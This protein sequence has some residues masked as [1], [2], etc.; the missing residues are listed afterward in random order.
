MLSL[1]VVSVQLSSDT[2]SKHSKLSRA[3]G[4]A[5]GLSWSQRLRSSLLR[6][7]KPP[8]TPWKVTPAAFGISSLVS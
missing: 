7:G 4:S 2:L 1:R 5:A 8:I 6:E 3:A